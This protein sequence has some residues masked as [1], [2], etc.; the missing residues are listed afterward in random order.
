MNKFIEQVAEFQQVFDPT[1]LSMDKNRLEKMECAA[2]N[3]L[4][5]F[6]SSLVKEEYKEF[7]A[8]MMEYAYLRSKKIDPCDAK[9]EILD[10]LCDMMYVVIGTGLA[11]GFDLEEA[12]NRVHASNMTKLGKDGKPVYDG[13]GKVMKGPDFKKP[14]LED[15]I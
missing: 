3:E 1:Q 8:A 15:L 12:F 14:D 9:R 10:A 11:L 6:R 5:S 7:R 2:V 13:N 4:L